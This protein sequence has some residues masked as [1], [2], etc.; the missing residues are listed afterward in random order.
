[1]MKTTLL[2]IALVLLSVNL[3]GQN[4]L[5]Y[6]AGRIEK[7]ISR[8]HTDLVRE[9]NSR[10]DH[11]KY[12]KYTDGTAG[13]STVYFF[14]SEQNKCNRI[15]SMHVHGLRDEVQKELDRMYVKTGEN[16]WTDRKKGR[17]ATIKLV[18]EEW[19]FSVTIEPVK[20]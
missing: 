14:L 12:L 19:F 8:N 10:N 1:M 6:K 17:D 2:Y 9:E 13:T 16:T 5:G 15:K 4:L 11:Y 20:K 7:Y 18:N 3:T